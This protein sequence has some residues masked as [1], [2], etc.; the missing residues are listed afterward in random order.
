MAPVHEAARLNEVVALGRLLDEDPGQVD[1]EDEASWLG[2]PL[3]EACASNALDA[4]R[5]L[6]DRG[7]GVDRANHQGKTALMVA[8]LQG[9]SGEC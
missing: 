8:C 3:H 5:L 6:L 9:R 4:A 1:A 7:A 2:L